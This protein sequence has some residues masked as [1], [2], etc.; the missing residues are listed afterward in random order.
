MKP[1][2]LDRLEAERE[3]RGISKRQFALE[4]LGISAQVY[5]HWF[6]RGV[7]E[8]QGR[9]ITGRL[10][11]S[12]DYLWHGKDGSAVADEKSGTLQRVDEIARSLSDSA[13]ND[14]LNFA[15][16]LEWRDNAPKKPKQKEAVTEG[17]KRRDVE[18]A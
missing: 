10:R 13:R 9:S 1:T 18:R 16:Y 4:V 8:D 14:L 2:P 17:E 5:N 15:K 12:L 6:E 7:P 3:K 11:W